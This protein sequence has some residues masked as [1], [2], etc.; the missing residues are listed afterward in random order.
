MKILGY[1]FNKKETKTEPKEFGGYESMSL[2]AVTDLPKIK[3]DRT[4]EWVKYGD[5]N[6]Y[7]EYLKDM[8]NSSPTHAA[9]VKTKAQMVVGEEW[10]FNDEYLN[11]K[12]KI[13]VLKIVN[14]IKREAYSY[15]LDFQLQGAMAFEI[16]W[17]LDFS[18]IVGVNRLDV[19]KIRSGKFEDGKICE[20]YYKRNW[21][22]RREEVTEIKALD[23]GNRENHRQILYVPATM[24]SNEYYGEPSYLPA[25]DWITLESQV[26]VYYN[27]LIQNGFNPSMVVKYYKRPANNEERNDIVRGLKGTYGGVKKAGSV[28]ILFSD[29][30]ELAPDV[31]PIAVANVDKQFTVISDQI[32]TKILTGERATTPE[33][34]GIAV[35]GQLGTGDFEAKLKAF[36]RF[37]INPDQ[38]VF[39]DAI[40]KILSINGYDVQFKIKDF[41]F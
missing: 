8:F 14:G 5:D 13:E 25:M 3:E 29:G 32:T 35:P 16:I 27:S 36:S 9:I 17:S 11:E 7:P 38:K 31:E 20:Y 10:T 40:N 34:F 26:G 1:D 12:E 41:E 37:V 6:L 28:M 18:K 22:D 23:L 30:K 19:S 33:L 4:Q 2:T 15:S 39:E 21:S 24:V